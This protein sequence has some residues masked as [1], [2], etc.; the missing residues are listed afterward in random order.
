MIPTLVTY[1]SL[2]YLIIIF[3]SRLQACDII[4]VI[5][6]ESYQVFFLI[7]HFSVLYIMFVLPNVLQTIVCFILI[8]KLRITLFMINLKVYLYINKY[9]YITIYSRCRTILRFLLMTG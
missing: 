9:N 6:F 1:L 4:F 3:G 7:C 2:L 8:G 5:C